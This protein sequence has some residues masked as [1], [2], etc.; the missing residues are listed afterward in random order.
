[1]LRA[2]NSTGYNRVWDVELKDIVDAAVELGGRPADGR[3]LYSGDRD[4]F[5]RL[6]FPDRK[7]DL[8][9]DGKWVM[10]GIIVGNS[11]VGARSLSF[12]LFWYEL[13]CTNGMTAITKGLRQTRRHVGS[14]RDLLDSVKD[15]LP[16][17]LNQ[18]VE[19]DVRVMQAALELDF[20]STQEDAVEGLKKK[21]FSK[22][23]SERAVEVA[24]EEFEDLSIYSLVF[25]LTREAK[26]IPFAAERQEAE[27][28]AS[29]LFLLAA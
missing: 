9:G 15:T 1:M 25:A 10:P 2:L 27:D 16:V 13:V 19:H 24:Q 17:H 7:T 4:S 14:V 18:L 28:K 26:A 3:A 6:I 23:L 22:K 29:R 8:N 20:A 21:G 11:E 12:Q 5:A